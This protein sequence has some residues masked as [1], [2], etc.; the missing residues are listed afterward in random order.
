MAKGAATEKQ[1]GKMHS[2][3]AQVFTRCLEKQLKVYEAM[4]KIPEGEIEADM[5]EALSEMTEPNPAMLSAM[6]KFLKDNEIGLDS[7]EVETLNATERR[8]AEKREKRKR[9]GTLLSLVPHVAAS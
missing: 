2:M 4:D 8:L 5:L 1:L 3:L 9:A 7:E 6:S